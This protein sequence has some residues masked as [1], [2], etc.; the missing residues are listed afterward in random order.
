ML[1]LDQQQRDRPGRMTHSEPL[2]LELARGP[3]LPKAPMGTEE[4]GAPTIF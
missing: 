4:G 3:Y 2:A 1:P